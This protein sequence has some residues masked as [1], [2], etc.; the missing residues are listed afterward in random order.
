MT[1]RIRSNVAIALLAFCSHAIGDGILDSGFRKTAP[2]PT[3]HFSAAHVASTDARALRGD[4]RS[5]ARSALESLRKELERAG[6]SFETVVAV[7][8]YLA[9]DQSGTYLYDYRGWYD[10]YRDVFGTTAF[11]ERPVMTVIGVAALEDPATLIQ[12]DAIAARPSDNDSSTGLFF[13]AGHLG[14]S[15]SSADRSFDMKTQARSALVELQQ[16]LSDHGIG[17][18]D[19]LAAR[20]MLMPDRDGKSDFAGWREGYAAF[21]SKL[22]VGHDPEPN[23]ISVG[24]GYTLY[25]YKTEIELVASIPGAA[26]L[27]EQTPPTGTNPVLRSFGEPELTYNFGVAV[28]DDA[29]YTWFSG[30]LGS[31][32]G[33]LAQ[34]AAAVFAELDRR[35]TK[36]GLGWSDVVEMRTYYDTDL[37]IPDMFAAYRP[38]RQ[39]YLNNAENPHKPAGTSL[40]VTDLPGDALIQIE[41]MAASPVM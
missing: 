17:F 4:T 32:G 27:F 37:S 21:R 10:A 7:R 15:P 11:R 2:G 31:G 26:N 9:P 1:H 6:Y 30:V 34:Q 24:P 14:T 41:L 36:A 35:L 23:L 18:G 20:A 38:A 12:I 3:L 22:S 16:L 19:V 33:D 40:K 5:Q 28:R 13:T 8:A 25:G 39:R 29:R